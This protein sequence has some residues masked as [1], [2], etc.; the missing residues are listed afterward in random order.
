MGSRHQASR[1]A[2]SLKEFAPSQADDLA[3]IDEVEH[4]VQMG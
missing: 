2:T 1:G 3:V 4:F